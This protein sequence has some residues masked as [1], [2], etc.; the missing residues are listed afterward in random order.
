MAQADVAVLKQGASLQACA[1]VAQAVWAGKKKDQ[2]G[3]RFQWHQMPSTCGGAT[4]F[5]LM[6]SP[7]SRAVAV[8]SSASQG[9]LSFSHPFHSS[10]PPRAAPA[11]P[12]TL[13]SPTSLSIFPSAAVDAVHQQEG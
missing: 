3:R 4:P 6:G 7:P 13:S 8:S 10:W 2:G 9:F 1:V 12:P 5:R 11:P